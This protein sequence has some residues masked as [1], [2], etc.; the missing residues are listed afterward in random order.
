MSCKISFWSLLLDLSQNK[1]RLIAAALSGGVDSSVA[2]ALALKA[3]YDVVAVTLQLK[4]CDMPGIISPCCGVDAIGRAKAVAQLLNIPHYCL[5]YSEQFQENVLRHAWNEYDSGR[6]P[7]PCLLCNRYIKFGLLMDWATEKKATGMV[8]GHYARLQH[9]PKKGP[10][11]FRAVDRNKDQSYF[12]A[13]IPKSTLA[14]LQFPL[15]GMTKPEVRALAQ[16]MGLPT[17]STVDSQDACFLAPGMTF[18]SILQQRFAG[19]TR[20][21]KVIDDDGNVLGQHSGI[22]NYTIGQRQG[23]G[24]ASKSRM[25]IRQ[26]RKEDAT[27]VV[28]FDSDKL[29]SKHMEVSN[30]NWLQEVTVGDSLNCQVQIRS[31]HSP[32]NASIK[33]VSQDIVVVSFD[34]PAKA[35][36]PGQAAVFYDQDMV[37]GQGWIDG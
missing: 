8:T 31:R 29:S 14:K 13:A 3:G 7:S 9:D 25:W 35:I 16:Q 12:L 19:Q 20:P 11:L 18:G 23:L 30:L 15:G 24:I 22:H 17:S 21:G 5:D 27:I 32:Q 33:V 34:E 26:I 10:T 1:K 37:I 4:N 36:S 2:A 6:T 28:T